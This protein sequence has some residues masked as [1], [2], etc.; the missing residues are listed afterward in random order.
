MKTTGLDF[1]EAVKAAK[2]GKKI[3]RKCWHSHEY[4]YDANG[5]YIR[6]DKSQCNFCFGDYVDEDWEIVPE[7]PKTMRFMEA[8][9]QAKQGKKIARLAWGGDVVVFFD[10]EDATDW[11][12]VED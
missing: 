12:V 9:E 2:L 8:W 1:I 4:I 6:R 5:E 10:E 3:R 7:P 11:V